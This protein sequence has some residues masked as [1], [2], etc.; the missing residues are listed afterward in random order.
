MCLK[1]FCGG[2]EAE[3]LRLLPP[4]KK[5]GAAFQ[6]VN[7]LRDLK[8]D[9]EERGRIYFPE[10]DF[11]VFNQEDKLKIEADIEA[12]FKDAYEGIKQLPMGARMGVHLAYVYYLKLFE[13]IRIC[14]A[15][16]IMNERI[17]I[18]DSK[19]LGLLL[20]T[21]LKYRINLSST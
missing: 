4:A 15:N 2:N 12:D 8:S 10:V 13:K 11:K 9:F 5:L 18:P 1:V 17:R 16:R 6:K 14:P 7:F 3:Y 21:W 19:K 20:E